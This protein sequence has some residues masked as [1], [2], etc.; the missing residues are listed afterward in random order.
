MLSNGAFPNNTEEEEFD[1]SGLVSLELLRL[2]TTEEPLEKCA[3]NLLESFPIARSQFTVSTPIRCCRAI[4]EAMDFWSKD[5]MD[6]FGSS[7]RVSW[8]T[9]LQSMLLLLEISERLIRVMFCVGSL[10]SM[11]L[12]GLRSL[13]RL[14]NSP[15]R[16]PLLAMILSMLYL[17]VS[18]FVTAFTPRNLIAAMSYASAASS[19]VPENHCNEKKLNMITMQ[20]QIIKLKLGLF[21]YYSW[22]IAQLKVQKE[23]KFHTSSVRFKKYNMN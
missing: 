7:S 20:G 16:R 13:F 3:L 19:C 15:E 6:A 10:C 14:A 4:P 5:S 21:K 23:T 12:V 9:V 22:H 18:K 1:L 8:N 17:E 2:L 11:A